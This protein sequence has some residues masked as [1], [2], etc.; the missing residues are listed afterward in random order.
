MDNDL[1]YNAKVTFEDG[2]SALIYVNR[3]SNENLNHWKGWICNAGVTGIHIYKNQVYGGECKNDLLG[4]TDQD[5]QLIENHAVCRQ[6][7]CLG[8]TADLLQEKQS[9]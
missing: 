5:W 3:L 6:D 4:Y 9:P 8:C 1:N 7:R 2:D